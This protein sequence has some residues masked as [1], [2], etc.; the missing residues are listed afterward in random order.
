MLYS[1]F[2]SPTGGTEKV[3]ECL[4]DAW[5]ECEVID[6]SNPK[7]DFAQFHFA[8]NNICMIGIPVFEGRVP[9]VALKR[10]S[11]MNANKTP[12]VLAAVFGNRD[13]DDALLELKH[14][15]LSLGFV[16]FAAV[17][18]VAQHSILPMYAKGRPDE[19]DQAELRSFSAKLKAALQEPM[20]VVE[21]PGKEPYIVIPVAPTYPLFKAEKCTGCMTCAEK[22]PVQAIDME[23]PAKLDTS[24]CAR[25][26]RCVAVCP[27]GAR[28]LDA[29]G[30]KASAE[31]LA[32]LFEG[33]KP[34]TLYL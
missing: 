7:S 22:C 23:E 8:E 11:M 13:I 33:R 25:C 5:E 24:L 30:Q 1:I 19:A 16:P 9:P 34:N 29:E 6:L 3:M 21:V 17:S 10:L 14:A 20:R 31:R 18:A 15:V 12:C 2:F 32:K 27:T 4:T 28:C 26:V